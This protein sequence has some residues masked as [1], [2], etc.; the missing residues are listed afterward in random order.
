M[1]TGFRLTG[2]ERHAAA[3]AA[4]G[5]GPVRTRRFLEGYEPAAAWEALTQGR[6]RADPDRAYQTKARPALLEAVE[7]ACTGAGIAVHILG[8]PGYPEALAADHEAPGV[9]FSLGDRRSS[10]AGRG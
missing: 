4:L 7:S 10:T 6:H 2:D 3:I 1:T 9:L 5:A 8:R